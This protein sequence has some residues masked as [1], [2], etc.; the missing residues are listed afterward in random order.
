M[1]SV[2]VD[3]AAA[4]VITVADV[5]QTH[6]LVETIKPRLPDLT[7]VARARDSAEAR[8]LLDAG[9]DVSVPETLEAS[10]VLGGAV[11]R[12]FA[13]AESE[14]QDALTALRADSGFL[15]EADR[16]LWG[17][18]TGRIK[19]ARDSSDLGGDGAAAASAEVP[20]EAGEE[21]AAK[22]EKVRRDR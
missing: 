13:I 18:Y 8:A 17:A 1:W 10:L 5:E 7:L 14:V 20:A 16:P 2:G 22:S 9:A 12:L 3:R 15:S 19:G 21:A 11:L 4:L 6:R